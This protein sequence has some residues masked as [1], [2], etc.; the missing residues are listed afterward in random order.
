MCNTNVNL[1]KLILDISKLNKDY[2]A[3]ETNKELIN[4]F[5]HNDLINDWHIER[6]RRVN[7]SVEHLIS[8]LQRMQVY[9]ESLVKVN[10]FDSYEYYDKT[11]NFRASCRDVCINIEIYIENIKTFIRYYFFMN[12]R[13]NDDT[14]K[15]IKTLHAYENMI[16]WNY[17]EDFITTCQ[18]FYSD[19]SVEFLR[20]IRNKEVHNASP[21]ELINYKFENGQLIPI[22]VDYVISN[23]ELHRNII[24]TIAILVNVVE[25][26]QILLENISPNKVYNYLLP[27]DG[28]IDNIIKMS[29]RY[30]KEREYFKKL[31]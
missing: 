11:K 26:L 2:I 18:V 9:A 5:T 21:I 4:E 25:K 13:K 29:D 15:W 7:S 17:I 24:H 22:P 16:E 30:K 10:D 27:I 12:Y 28:K 20:N 19:K 6:I 23:Q 8:S 3:Y 14:I 31:I 1:S